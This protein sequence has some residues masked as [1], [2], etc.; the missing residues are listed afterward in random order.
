MDIIL[1]GFAFALL[2]IANVIAVI[3]ARE[4]TIDAPMLPPRKELTNNGQSAR[5][6]LFGGLL[7]LSASASGAVAGDQIGQQKVK[8]PGTDY[9]ISLG[10]ADGKLEDLLRP[11][12]LTAVE[13]WLAIHFDLPATDSHPNIKIVSPEKIVS[14][15]YGS[16]LSNVASER[17]AQIKSIASDT[18]AIYVDAERAIYLSDSW[19]D[20]NISY[21]SVLV[22]EMV[23]HM[24]NSAGLKY[25][26]TQEREKLAYM[27]QERWLGLFGRSLEQ[28]FALDAFS[29]FPKT[30]CLY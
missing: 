1:G 25:A 22:H 6:A 9:E 12:L 15:R 26:C 20:G 29:L 14:L 5:T 7:W 23:H 16:L 8:I 13:T 18:V 28:D 2:A 30:R 21:L 10:V 4:W 3:A 27:A 11:A 24:Q 19:T 17:A